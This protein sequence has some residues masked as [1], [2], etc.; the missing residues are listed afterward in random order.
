MTP[1]DLPPAE[2]LLIRL[3]VITG[4]LHDWAAKGISSSGAALTEPNNRG[5]PRLIFSGLP[6]SPLPPRRALSF[7]FTCTRHISRA[8]SSRMHA[9]TYLHVY[10]TYAW[11]REVC[12]L[13]SVWFPLLIK[14]EHGSSFFFPFLNWAMSST[15][16]LVIINLLGRYRGGEM[17]RSKRGIKSRQLVNGGG[18]TTEGTLYVCPEIIRGKDSRSRRKGQWWSDRAIQRYRVWQ[19]WEGGRGDRGRQV[20]K[21]GWGGWRGGTAGQGGEVKME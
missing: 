9:C 15:V 20:E 12:L 11:K 14:G 5:F 7:T 3:E 21:G 17:E 19:A 18:G 6:D 16:L 2:L 10:C 4:G 8:H 13:R 1:A